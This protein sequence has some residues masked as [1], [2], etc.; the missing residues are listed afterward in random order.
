MTEKRDK[1]VQD[2]NVCLRFVKKRFWS[3]IIKELL[4]LFEHRI[5]CEAEPCE[6]KV[7]RGGKKYIVCHLLAQ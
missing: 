2:I 5:K 3:E 4:T 1:I 6:V 7:H